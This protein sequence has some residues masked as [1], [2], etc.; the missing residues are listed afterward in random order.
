MK[1][2]FSNYIKN[3]IKSYRDLPFCLY[4]IQNKFR[5]EIRPRFGLMRAR[6]FIMKDA[7]SF[8]LDEKQAKQSY[9]KMRFIYQAIFSRLGVPFRIVKA[10]SGEIG[11]D[12]SEEFHI[13]ADHGED[14]LLFTDSFAANREIC[15]VAVSEEVLSKESFCLSKNY[16]RV[17]YPRNK[18]NRTTFSFFKNFLKIN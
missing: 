1:R 10:D 13:L 5:D 3:N 7:Y 12:L 11:G 14:E 8:D 16:G 18:N 15:P 9:E 2:L 4:Q 17:S 6:E